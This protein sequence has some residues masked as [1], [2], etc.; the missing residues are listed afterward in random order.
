VA[1]YHLD[2]WGNFRFPNEL[3]SSRNRF[4]FTGHI[5]DDE[6][7]LYNA[8]AR[9]FD[10]KLGRFLTQDSY[11]G[12]I[13][14]PPSLHRYLYGLNNP[15]LYIDPTGHYS[16]SEFK[17]DASWT[18]DFIVAAGSDLAQ[19]APDR[20]VRI[21]GSTFEQAGHL[22][23]QTGAMA[24][25][26]AV[27]AADAAVRT[28]TGQGLDSVTLY[29]DLAH[30][31]GQ[32]IARGDSVGS[33]IGDSA[34]E[35]GANA[36]T[37][38]TYGT[39][40]EQFSTAA[41]YMSGNA[42]IEQVESRLINAAGGAILNAG[43]GAAGAK[44][45]GEGWMGKPV[46][47]PSPATVV[48]SVSQLSGRA[49]AAAQSA[50]D[51]TSRVLNSEVQITPQYGVASAFGA[52]SFKLGLVPPGGARR[53]SAFAS[54]ERRPTSI[55]EVLDTTSGDSIY[56]GKTFQQGGAQRRFCQ[57]ECVKPE[58]QGQGYEVRALKSG[59]WTEFEAATHEM[60][61]MMDRGGPRSVNP[62]TTLQNKNRSITPRKFEK[63]RSL[64]SDY[65]PNPF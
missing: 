20:A 12:Q 57:H 50:W 36:L 26:T 61:A 37:V 56:V 32:R 28:A 52:G 4:A 13:D 48:E 11:L 22:A 3:D 21:V 51:A 42:S 23:V 38:G 9:Y 35:M 5:Y 43:L 62:N 14:E 33:I 45:A 6:T 2:A 7:G 1:S 53:P 29:S 54:V 24:H 40:K 58:W 27:L 31:A 8:K 18:K 64:H 17:Q 55:Y 60:R 34:L 65:E 15:T 25:D 39:F 46:S 16:W 59:D 10:P 44:V 63:Y 30:G 19:N 47:V 49:R 41:D